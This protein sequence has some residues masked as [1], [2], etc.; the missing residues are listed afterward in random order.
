MK[1]Y[2]TV[3]LYGNVSMQRGYCK[4]CGGMAFI[5]NGRYAC[6]GELA[7]GTPTKFERMTEPFFGRKTPSKSQKDR[8]LREQNDRCFYCSVLL[9]SY[10]YKNSMPFLIKINWDHRLPFAYS[11]NNKTENFV[12]ACHVCNGIKSDHLF[13]TIEEAQVYIAEKRKS[14]GY[15]F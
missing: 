7:E 8:I 5:K 12:A 9:G 13:Q 10:R 14:K 4:E 6:C 15:D 1:K 3:T 11:Q 2:N